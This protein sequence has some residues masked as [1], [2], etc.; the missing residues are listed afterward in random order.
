MVTFSEKLEEKK[1]SFSFRKEERLCSKKLIDK[2]FAEGNS[3]LI[4]PLKVQFVET[5]LPVNYRLQVAFSVSK[6]I[7]KRAVQRNLIKRRMREAYRLNKHNISSN[8]KDRQLAV[9]FIYVGKEI[10]DYR[11]IE[12]SMK[13]ALKKLQTIHSTEKK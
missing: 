1:I 12:L 4:F 13:K 5:A 8:L 9:T 6:K 2:L 11:T 7:F 10:L 3:F